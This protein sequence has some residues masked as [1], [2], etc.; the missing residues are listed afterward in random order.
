MKVLYSGDL[1]V[2]RTDSK[3]SKHIEFMWS[4]SDSN[5]FEAHRIHVKLFYRS[6]SGSNRFE[7]L[8]RH[9]INVKVPYIAGLLVVRTVSQHIESMSNYFIV[10]VYKWFKQV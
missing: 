7:T 3:F 4:T 5:R 1:I 8:K 10:L 6:T 9:R 2:V